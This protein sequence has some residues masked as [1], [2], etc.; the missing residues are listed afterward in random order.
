MNIEKWKNQTALSYL[1]VD[2]SEGFLTDL[3]KKGHHLPES[4][5]RAVL[6]RQC[7]FLSGRECVRQAFTQRG[8]RTRFKLD[9]GEFNQPIWPEGFIGSISHCDGHAVAAVGRPNASC[10]SLGI[11]IENHICRSLAVDISQELIKQSERDFSHCFRN[12]ESFITVVFSAK[13]S[14]YKAVFP[15]V[16][17]ILGFESATLVS[18]DKNEM[19]MTFQPEGLLSQRFNGVFTVYFHELFSGVILTWCSISEKDLS[20]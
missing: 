8:E 1:K 3:L 10:I 14:I 7:E 4:L 18:V 13:E 16:K 19:T 6:K 11:D 12:F 15:H 5:N 20:Q 17:Q 9:I 2:Y